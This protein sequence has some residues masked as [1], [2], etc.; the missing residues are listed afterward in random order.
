MHVLEKGQLDALLQSVRDL[1][2]TRLPA[3]NRALRHLIE[4]EQRRYM[5]D[6]V[7]THWDELRADGDDMALA[8]LLARRLGRSLSG[9]GIER[10][11][12]E[13][14]GAG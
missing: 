3:L 7:A 4:D 8:Y 6:F 11:A 13:L 14:G 2:A 10:V 12:A 9:P 5:W 1:F